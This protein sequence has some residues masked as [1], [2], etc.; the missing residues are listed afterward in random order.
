MTEREICE[1]IVK[2]G[3]CIGIDCTGRC[4]GFINKGT[5]CPFFRHHTPCNIVMVDQAQKWL[6]DHSVL[7]RQVLIDQ[8]M[9]TLVEIMKEKLEENSFKGTWENMDNE[10]L[11]SYLRFET[12]ELSDAIFSEPDE[13]IIR[14]CADIANFAMMIAGNAR[15]RI[16]EK[17]R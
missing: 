12:V 2:Q 14:E 3:N 15:R 13:A 6:D 7:S 17:T 16:D 5:P 1:L 11:F 8:D 10:D 4:K 9:A